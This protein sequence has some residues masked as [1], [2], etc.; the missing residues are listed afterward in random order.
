MEGA[1]DVPNVAPIPEHMPQGFFKQNVYHIEDIGE[2]SSPCFLTTST[3]NPTD[4]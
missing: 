1:M 2:P 3:T 4:W